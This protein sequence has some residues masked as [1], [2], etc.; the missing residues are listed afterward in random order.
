MEFKEF[1][2]ELLDMNRK[3]DIQLSD[4]QIKQ[5]YIYMK[6]IHDWNERVNLT[7]I[8]EPREMILKHFID[9]MTILKYIKENDKIVDIGT[10][11]GFPGLPIKIAK[12]N[13]KIVLIDSLNKRIKFL[14]TVIDNLNLNDIQSMHLRAE[15]FGSNNL[16]REKFDIAVSRAVAPMN[17][18]VEYLLP[19]VKVGGSCICMKGP[20]IE[21]EI[22]NSKKALEILGGKIEKIEKL[23]L[24][25]SDNKRTI[26]V[27]KKVKQTPNKYPRKAGIP[28]KKPI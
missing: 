8:L 18:L 15:D 9:S 20:E 1:K 17:I 5:F 27:I 19:A 10:G 16:Y 3:I 2:E 14:D 13:T 11:A 23:E 4:N 22:E 12:T 26:I 21:P 24:T 25:N 28:S 6:L 7:A